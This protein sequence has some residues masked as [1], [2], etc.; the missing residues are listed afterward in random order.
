MAGE[1]IPIDEAKV[2]T[3]AWRVAFPDSTKA[4]MADSVKIQ[5]L[6]SQPGCVGMRMYF[7]INEDNEK[8]LVLVG[9]DE[10]GNDL[11]NGLI[12]DKVKL[13]PNHCPSPNPLN[14]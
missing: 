9:T 11:Y 8:T 2:M 1:F 10:D 14:G 3:K 6:L 13:C 7:A 12:L 4:G 5:E